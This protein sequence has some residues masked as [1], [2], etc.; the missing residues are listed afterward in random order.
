MQATS[1]TFLGLP[2]AKGPDD[3]LARSRDG[4]HVEGGAHVGAPAPTGPGA[5]SGC[6]RLSAERAIGS[7]SPGEIGP[8]AGGLPV[9]ASSRQLAFRTATIRCGSSRTWSSAVRIW[10]T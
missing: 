9:K 3:R 10:T 4:G 8:P 2:W 7:R 1:A 5:V 6:F